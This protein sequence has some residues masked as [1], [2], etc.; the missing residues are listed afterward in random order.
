VI[1]WLQGQTN[2]ST[3]RYFRNWMYLVQRISGAV[4]FLFII[5]HVWGTRLQVLLADAVTKDN[6]FEHLA[7]QLDKTLNIAWYSIG[8][9]ASVIHLSNGLW[10]VLITW[11]ITIGPRSQ[12]ISTYVCAGI[13]LLLLLLS[14]QALRGFINPLEIAEAAAEA[15]Q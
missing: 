8:I 7:G 12:R 14:A 1:I 4:A 9:L 13:G 5:T 6:L 10:L 2:V 15:T 3:N 11:G